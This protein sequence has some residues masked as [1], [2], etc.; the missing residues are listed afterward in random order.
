VLRIGLHGPI[1][2]DS[3]LTTGAATI[4]S[5]LIAFDLG[6][7]IGVGQSFRFIA[8]TAADVLDPDVSVLFRNAASA[9]DYQIVEDASGALVHFDAAV[10]SGDREFLYGGE[11]HDEHAAGAGDDVLSGGGGDDVLS[12]SGGNDRLIGGAGR[13]TLTG[14]AGVDTFAFTAPSDGFP[15]EANLPAYAA[16]SV[17]DLIADF[18]S[19]EGDRLE[20]NAAA[21]DVASIDASNFVIMNE[22]Y[23]GANAA[24]NAGHAAGEPTFVFDGASNLIYDANGAAAGYTILAQ[25][26]NAALD[27]TQVQL[28]A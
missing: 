14:G 19:A 16:G 15:F 4:E 8:S 22:E 27:H 12:G 17:G 20:F 23:N 5:G 2:N 7:T 6:E 18:N 28:A 13:D 1:G 25:V 21:F 24:A 10:A 9:P 3:L 26:P 11:R